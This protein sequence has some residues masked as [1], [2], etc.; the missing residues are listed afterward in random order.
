MPDSCYRL[1]HVTRVVIESLGMLYMGH[2]ESLIPA[3]ALPPERET[4]AS[5][6]LSIAT[7]AYFNRTEIHLLNGSEIEVSTS[8]CTIPKSLCYDNDNGTIF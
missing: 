3:W 7:L 2:V 8:S 1:G 6:I 4:L 5:C